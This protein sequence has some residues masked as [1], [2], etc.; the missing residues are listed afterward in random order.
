MIIPFHDMEESVIPHFQGGEKEFRVKMF[1]DGLNKIMRARLVPGASIGYH[2]HD[3]SSEIVYILKG[4]GH[5][6]YE[7]EMIA[8]QAGDCHYCKKG[9]S[10]SLINDSD[11]DLEF[12]AVVPQ[13]P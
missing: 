8:L 2:V 12:F 10:H 3:A 4:R 11:A 1:N 13:Q 9:C 6:L 7:G 5:V